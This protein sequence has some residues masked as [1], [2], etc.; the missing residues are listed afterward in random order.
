MRFVTIAELPSTKCC[1][2][3]RLMAHR[4]KYTSHGA[5]KGHTYLIARLAAAVNKSVHR[6]GKKSGETGVRRGWNA[7]FEYTCEPLRSYNGIDRIWPPFR[8]W[9]RSKTVLQ[10]T[11]R[12]YVKKVEF[13]LDAEWNRCYSNDRFRAGSLRSVC[14]ICLIDVLAGSLINLFSL[15]CNCCFNTWK[16][17]KD[18][19]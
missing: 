11:I 10:G 4:G 7:S 12:W 13:I 5:G 19:S 2:Y 8:I 1:N 18:Q 16:F 15:H 3:H 17:R 9:L 14:I 6:E